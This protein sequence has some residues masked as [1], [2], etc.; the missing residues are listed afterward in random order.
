MIRALKMDVAELRRA[1]EILKSAS[2]FFAELDRPQVLIAFNDED[3]EE[4][5][6]EPICRLPMEHG[7]QTAPSIYYEARDR[8]PSSRGLTTRS[9]GTATARIRRVS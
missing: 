8:G 2:A 3:R 9:T 4:F 1:N 5:G 7:V 6:V